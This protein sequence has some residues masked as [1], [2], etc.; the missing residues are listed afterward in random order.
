MIMKK[1]SRRV[2]T[3][4]L[5]G[6]KGER[7]GPLTAHRSKPAV[8]FGGRYRI[9][10]FVLSNL[11]NSGLESVYV[12]TQYRAQSLLDHVQRG[13]A[14]AP[15]GRNS[16]ISVVPAQMQMGDDWYA[17]TADAVYQNLSRMTE[18]QPDA[19]AVFGADHIYK[20]DVARMVDAHFETGAGA[21]VACIPVPAAEAAAFGVVETDASGRVLAFHEKPAAPPMMPGRPGEAFASMGNYIFDPRVLAA[22]L[23]S[24]AERP[25]SHRDFG[26]DILPAM[27]AR[28]DVFAYDFAANA[29]PGGAKGEEAAY[30]RDVGTVD[31]YFD[32]NM[33]LRRVTPSL[34]LYGSQW[35]IMTARFND[36]PAKFI[37]DEGGRRG[38]A[39][40]SIVSPGCI[41]AGGAC[42][43]SVLGRN[44]VL[45]AGSE[46]DDCVLL[47]NVVLGAGA[48]VRRAII[49]KNVRIAPG[50]RIGHD[51]AA[52][53]TRFF[54]S[55]GGVVVIPKAPETPFT[56]ERGQR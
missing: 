54:V 56:R 5:A 46:A 50:D 35:P 12:L 32:A 17:G 28:G 13:W 37:F 47:D 15:G 7:L 22:I 55:P 23:R 43:G 45:D 24:D 51:A 18:F 44:V 27:S 29:V 48:R 40:D 16:F 21:T 49:D 34:N 30:W 20:M 14:A 33:D 41:L 26:R 1:R 53:R 36:P 42:R 3:F 2:L 19:V 11:V 8:P 31:A 38:C 9:V 52:D 10:D 6:G 39:I 25:D 4:V